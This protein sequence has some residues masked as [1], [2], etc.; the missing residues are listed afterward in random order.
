MS[1]TGTVRDGRRWVDIAVADLRAL[2]LQ[3]GDRV[4]VTGSFGDVIAGSVELD[5][6]GV[7]AI[8]L[9]AAV[10]LDGIVNIRRRRT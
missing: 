8:R 3:P 7:L 1:A 4:T 5:A 6:R 9:E 2:G 10:Y